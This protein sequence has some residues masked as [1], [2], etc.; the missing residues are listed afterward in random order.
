MDTDDIGKWLINEKNKFDALLSKN[1]I[2]PFTN[3]S[4]TLYNSPSSKINSKKNKS[5]VSSGDE[6][7]VNSFKTII[8]KT[9]TEGVIEFTNDYFLEMC[10]YS[11]SEVINQTHSLVHHPDMPQVILDKIFNYF[12]RGNTFDMFEKYKAKNGS[13]YWVLT[14]FETK[15]DKKSHV[16]SRYFRSKTVLDKQIPQI[17]RIYSILKSIEEK[18]DIMSANKYLNGLFED[19]NS[20]Y[21]Q[22]VLEILSFDKKSEVFPFADQNKKVAPKKRKRIINRLFN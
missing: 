15:I 22:S 8:S 17:E 4:T 10:G 19:K 18:K 1:N 16:T 11:S 2:Q 7:K 3:F 20:L 5:Q 13:F 9:N 14:T 21:D 6:I 12:R